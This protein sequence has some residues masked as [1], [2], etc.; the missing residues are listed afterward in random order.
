MNRRDLPA[1][2]RIRRADIH[3]A[4]AIAAVHVQSW[5]GAYRGLLP[6][7]Y[8]DNLT[9]AQRLPR[10]Q[11]TL[12]EID[13]PRAGT[14]VAEHDEHIIGFAHFSA[15]RDE[16]QD[17]AAVGELTS[18]YVLPT[19]WGHGTGRRLMSAALAALHDAR[20][21]QATLWVLTTNNRATRFYL[22]TGWHPDGATKQEHIAGQS[23]SETRYRR[24][25]P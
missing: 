24:A 4:Q 3:D 15:T 5:Q 25:I 20:F 6:Q 19:N 17:P 9:P 1:L 22:S 14:V 18:I 16:D 10:W 23:I 7:D 21:M 2:P 8:L 11:Q 12:L 13:W